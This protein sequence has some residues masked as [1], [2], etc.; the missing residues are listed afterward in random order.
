[1]FRLIDEINTDAAFRQNNN[2]KWSKSNW[3]VTRSL[4]LNC[5]I[6]K[7]KHLTAWAMVC[8]CASLFIYD[9]FLSEPDKMV[10]LYK[11][12]QSVDIA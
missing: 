4:L 8:S 5:M 10:L 11:Q 3:S 1:L 12:M 6:V 9:L 7:K 2:G